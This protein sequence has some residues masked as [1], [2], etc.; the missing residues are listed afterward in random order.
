MSKSSTR[1]QPS[2]PASERLR[3]CAG[4]LLSISTVVGKM[5]A[6]LPAKSV[7]Q[8]LSACGPSLKFVVCTVTSSAAPS[9]QGRICVA[10]HSPSIIAFAQGYSV[11]PTRLPSSSVSLKRTPPPVSLSQ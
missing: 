4:G 5:Q 10:R 8:R 11:R 6:L 9:G 7:A 2:P 1:C 3:G